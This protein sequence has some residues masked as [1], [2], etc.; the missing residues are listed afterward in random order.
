MENNINDPAVINDIIKINNDRIEGYNKAIELA[1]NHGLHE[2]EA[3]FRKY[4]EQSESFITELTPY[5]KLEGEEP[6][7]STMLSGKLFRTWMGIKVTIA[8]ND[9]KSLLES[10]EKGEDAF[11]ATYKK[12]LEDDDDT[13]SPS[14]KN[15]LTIQLNKQLEAHDHIKMLRDNASL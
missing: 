5:V 7:D 13:L 8:G 3:D 12:I 6:T 1:H 10:C 11:K 14:V 9:K 15:V 2:L 4:I